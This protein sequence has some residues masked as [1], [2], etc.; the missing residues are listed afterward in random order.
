MKKLTV[1]IALLTGATLFANANDV[2]ING[3]NVSEYENLAPIRAPKNEEA[4]KL[5]PEN[6]KFANPG[7]FTVA[8]AGLNSPPLYQFA[9][10][11]KT[12]IGS[13]V[14]MARIIAD[15]LGLELNVVITSWEDWPLGIVSGKYDAAISNITV[16]KARK[17]KFDFA[18][19]REDSLGFYV[20]KDSPI[21]SIKEAKDIAGLKIVVGSGTNQEAILL[22]W[23]AEN[24]ANGLEPFTPVYSRDDAAQTLALQSGRAD[25]TFGPY[26]I[27]EWKVSLKGDTKL[28]GQVNGGWPANANIGVTLKKGS[29]LVVPVQAAINA[30]IANGTY[31]QVLTRW[32][33]INEQLPASEINPKGLGD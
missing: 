16:T 26:V 28:V 25:A 2:V 30:T 22:A 21:E 19:Y 32:G 12:L 18:T 5:I 23:D 13:E 15:T 10:D 24:R 1:L 27:G 29:G 14:D 3:S 7:Q 9:S 6:F 33:E 11:N 20:K 8:V 4:I 17:E 31:A